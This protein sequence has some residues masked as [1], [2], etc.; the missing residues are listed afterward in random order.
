MGT[1]PCLNA[2]SKAEGARCPAAFGTPAERGEG[3]SEGKLQPAKKIASEGYPVGQWETI[4][5]ML[6][7]ESGVGRFWRRMR[8]L[9]KWPRIINT[10]RGCSGRLQR[11]T[12]WRQTPKKKSDD[13]FTTFLNSLLLEGDLSEATKH[14]ALLDTR[15]DGT[16]R[17]EDLPRSR[18]CLQGWRRMD[19]GQTRLPM[20]WELVALMIALNKQIKQEGTIVLLMFDTHLWL[21]APGGRCQQTSPSAH[22]PFQQ[23]G[24]NPRWVLQPRPQCWTRWPH[25][26][27][28]VC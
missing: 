13:T 11:P 27:W 21:G 2:C 8:C 17:A 1:S 28:E 16:H 10:D 14:L 26:E 3:V 4:H 6:W 7:G 18:R 20:P 15:P 25:H 19:P 9:W 24:K 5:D 22:S 12:S 23:T